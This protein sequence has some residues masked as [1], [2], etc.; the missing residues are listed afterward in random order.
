MQCGTVLDPEKFPLAGDKVFR[1]FE[2]DTHPRK[3]FESQ[4]AVSP[5]LDDF[6]RSVETD[7]GYAQ[8]QFGRCGVDFHGK[9]F[10]MAQRPSAFRVVSFGEV[11]VFVE[12]LL[13]GKSVKADQPVRLIKTV[14]PK[15]S[16]GACRQ[17][18]R[19]RIRGDIGRVVHPFERKSAIERLGQTENVSV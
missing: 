16:D 6:R 18:F 3:V 8:K 10:G 19:G 5:C 17:N 4:R 11:F 12:D 9:K 1:T 7:S 15:H 2:N 14:F 13:G